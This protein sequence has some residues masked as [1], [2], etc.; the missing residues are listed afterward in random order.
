MNTLRVKGLFFLIGAAAI[1]SRVF[2]FLDAIS[3]FNLQIPS[4]DAE[5]VSFFFSFFPPDSDQLVESAANFLLGVILETNGV[6]LGI[7]G[8]MCVLA[9]RGRL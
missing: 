1:I 9:A 6:H 8:L 3:R 2:M 4:C 7:T 5:E